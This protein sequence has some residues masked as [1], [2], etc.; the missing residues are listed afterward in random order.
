MLI[1]SLEVQ[2]ASMALCAAY[3]E[4]ENARIR[5]ETCGRSDRRGARTWGVVGLPDAQQFISSAMNA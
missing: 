4:I 1:R 2:A 3:E 5:I